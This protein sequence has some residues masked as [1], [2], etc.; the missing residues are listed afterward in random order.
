MVNITT[1]QGRLVRDPD[2]RTT[3]NGVAV[4]SFTVAWSEKY[5]DKETQC[6]LDCTAWRGTA[7]FVDKY[8]SKGKEILVQGSLETRKWTDKEGNNRSSINLQVDKV[9]FCGTKSGDGDTSNTYQGS[10]VLVDTTFDEMEDD[11]ELPF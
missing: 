10:G 9:H 7:E 8:F 1:L 5:K 3:P 2:L 4:V 11:G 6:F